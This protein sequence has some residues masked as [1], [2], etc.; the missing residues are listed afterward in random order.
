MSIQYHIDESFIQ[1]LNKAIKKVKIKSCVMIK[2]GSMIYEYHKNRKVR[3]NLQKVNSCTKSIVSALIGIAIQEGYISSLDE[4]LEHYFPKII[5]KQTDKRKKEITIEHLLTMTAGFDWPEFGEWDSFAPMVYSNDIVKFVI[6]RPLID[7]PGIKMNYNSGC[8][9]LLTAILQIATGLKVSIFAEKYL[10]DPLEMKYHWFEDNKGI[11]HGADGL[12]LTPY[13]MAKFGQLYLQKGMWNAKQLIP[14]Q[15]IKRSTEPKYL[16][17]D[18]IGHYSYHWWVKNIE[19]DNSHLS[20]D[21]R[22]F[23]A[24]GH[25]GQYIC[26]IPHAN[27]VVV[28]TSDMYNDSLK[29]LEYI[30]KFIIKSF[31]YC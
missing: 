26:I 31:S 4:T 13:D 30:E 17:Y 25:G 19:S 29:P 6:D 20:A 24:L 21:N 5:N 18:F 16:T 10:F 12:R 27:A 1:D 14:E 15:W 28:F 9:H 7:E 3:D 23:F 8:S 22:F 2:D 11:N